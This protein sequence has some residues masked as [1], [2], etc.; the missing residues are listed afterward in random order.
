MHAD[1]LRLDENYSYFEYLLHG[2]W[3]IIDGIDI[4][5]HSWPIICDL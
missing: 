1:D 2:E 4:N 5:R 3:K